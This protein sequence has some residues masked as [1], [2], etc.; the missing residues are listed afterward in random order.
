MPSPGQAHRRAYF[1]TGKMI[2][3]AVN[4]MHLNNSLRKVIRKIH[5]SQPHLT[6]LET[7]SFRGM[8]I[9]V[10][11]LEGRGMGPIKMLTWSSPTGSLETGTGRGAVK[12]REPGKCLELKGKKGS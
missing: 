9:F 4:P 10:Q 8:V 7:E 6:R 12:N 5:L 11:N 1:C 2:K 3:K